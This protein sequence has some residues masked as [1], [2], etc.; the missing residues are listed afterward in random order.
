MKNSK[1]SNQNILRSISLITLLLST[2]GSMYF[3][4]HAGS[5]QKSLVL[6]GL[7]T[8]WV[9]APFVGLFVLNRL[10][11]PITAK[12]STSVYYTTVVLSVTSLIIYSGAVT[13]AQTKPAFTFLVVPF[14]SWVVLL[15]LYFI[16]KRQY[17]KA[18]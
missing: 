2:I 6:I 5:N 10:A 17:R 16:L 3:M 11:Q 9:F 4:F 12:T 14:L 18:K 1:S 13:P 15:S 8:A 7:F